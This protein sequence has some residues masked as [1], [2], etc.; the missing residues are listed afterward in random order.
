MAAIVEL[1]NDG[2]Y[3]LKELLDVAE[4]AKSVFHYWKDRVSENKGPD[5]SLIAHIQS[6]VAE[7]N[8]TYGYRRVTMTL[9]EKGIIVNHKKVL[10]LMREN[11]LLCQKF[12]H[13]NRKYNSYKGKVGK[14][15]KNG[16]KRR[17]KTDRPFQKM[18]TDVTQFKITKTG[19]ILYLSPIMDL[20]N[21]E[22]V[23]YKVSAAPTLD[24]A[25]EPLNDL[26]NL[27]PKLKYRMTVHSDQGWQY[28][29]NSWVKTLKKHRIFQSMSRKG[30]CLDNSPMENFFGLLKQ[31]MFYGNQFKNY[32]ELE[33]AIHQYIHF[34]NNI[35]IKMKLE[36]MS[37]VNYR[38]HTFEKN[39]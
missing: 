4:I 23:S 38:N 8:E 34:Y 28:Q 3:M 31:E 17:F 26:I 10:R 1:R 12:R 24:I 14:V 15:A 35:R 7:S 16:M 32:K 5:Q 9:K 19:E 29:H 37:P 22:I 39:A 27:R 36:G 2:I 33:S 25:T 30:N 21:G 11:D 20:Y 13:R 6:I 18:L